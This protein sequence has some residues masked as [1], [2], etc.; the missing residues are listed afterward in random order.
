MN[1]AALREAARALDPERAIAALDAAFAAWR[2]PGSALR[3][4]LAH[5]LPIHSAEVLELG[6]RE[7]LRAW[8]AD[9]MRQ[10]RASEL[11]EPCRVPE[12]TAVW[13]AGSIPPSIFAAIALPLLAGS[14]VYAK[15]SSDDGISA[16]LFAES[17]RD[18]DAGVGAAVQV[19]RKDAA[20]DHADAVVAHG[21]D[22]TIALLRAR[23][24]SARPFV[25]YGHKLSVAVVLSAA[26]LE[27]AAAHCAR[28]AALYDGRGCLSPH[29][30]LV[31]DADGTR[32]RRFGDLLADEL[33]RLATTLPRG[34]LSHAEQLAL[35]ELRARFALAEHAQ[36]L[37]SPGG[38][39]W[40]VLCAA[41]GS[42][43]EPGLLRHLPV[44]P[45]PDRAA[46]EHWCAA[47]APHLS[48]LGV[49]GT[50]REREEL[51]SATKAGGGSR[52]CALGRMQLPPL[53]WRH[54]GLGAIE[55]L[56]RTIDVEREDER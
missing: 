36:A 34:R 56:L 46:L 8:T 44:V 32:A 42:R 40:G 14:A 39:D 23:V 51:I 7:G 45:V 25:G 49:T 9:V 11:S 19:G 4:R 24:G 3:E 50:S 35:R 52:V 2:A 30:V 15:P 1:E 37:L 48:S 31:E 33:G 26:D 18:A 20:L 22:E 12:L 43:P 21:S 41:T 28:D 6:L 47:L 38:T 10:I 53:D 13:L 54:D 17:L 5:E 16:V 29:F 27:Q 55:P